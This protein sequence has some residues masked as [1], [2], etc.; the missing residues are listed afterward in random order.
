MKTTYTLLVTLLFC[1]LNISAQQKEVSIYLNHYYNG[2]V[3][4]LDEIYPVDND[5]NCQISRLEY[6]L[7]VNTLYSSNGDSISFGGEFYTAEDSLINYNGKSLLVRTSKHKYSLGNLDIKEL[8]QMKFHIGVP[9]EINHQDPVIWPSN[10]ALAP[11]DPSMHWGWNSGYR[12]LALEAMVDEN[13][14]GIFESVL[15]YHAVGDTLYRTLHQT[16]STVET[17][18]EIIIYLDVNFENLLVNINASDAGV[19][20][21]EQTQVMGLMDNFAFNSVFTNTVNL[22]LS[23]P[24]VLGSIFPNPFSNQINIQVIEP[25]ELK[26]YSVLGKLVYQNVVT[27]GTHTIQT[28]FLE[29][30]LYIFKLNTKEESRSI[31]LLKN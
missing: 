20:H 1:S 12:F 23:S 8:N 9:S 24:T 7:T 17:D 14:D 30:G 22:S 26:V 19:F 27:K 29:Q 11:K 21:G 6:Y 4:E 15:Q 28:D 13:E 5:I 2:E 18:E 3:F 31:K 10:H 16:I 25:T